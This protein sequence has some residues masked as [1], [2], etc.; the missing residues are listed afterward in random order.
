MIALQSTLLRL[1]TP[2]LSH[3][4]SLLTSCN[5]QASSGLQFLLAGSPE[6]VL[7][8]HGFLPYLCQDKGAH[9]P[10]ALCTDGLFEL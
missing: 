9:C 10:L 1:A 7:K 5:S 3:R 6:H 2:C 4:S 8:L